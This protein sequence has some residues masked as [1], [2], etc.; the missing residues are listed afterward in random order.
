MINSLSG[1]GSYQSLFSTQQTN[2]TSQA[3]TSFDDVLQS[4]AQNSTEA[5]EESEATTLS[6]ASGGGSSS[7]GTNSE[8]DLNNDGQVTIDE[9][10]R[11]M[12]MQQAGNDFEQAASEEGSQQMAQENSNTISL[13]DF[14]IQQASK[15][16]KSSQMILSDV[17]EM[18]A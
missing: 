1:I 8:M 2:S 3:V 15:A 12:E 9:I 5:T 17:T 4:S 16:Y 6:G 14:K 18:F 11:Y 10:L 13:E 7:S